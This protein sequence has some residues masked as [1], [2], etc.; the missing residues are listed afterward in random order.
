MG[1]G[2]GVTAGKEA[3]RVTTGGFMRGGAMFKRPGYFWRSNSAR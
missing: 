3:Q 1:G 2:D